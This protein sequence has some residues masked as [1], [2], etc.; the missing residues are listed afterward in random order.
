VSCLDDTTRRRLQDH[1]SDGLMTVIGS[2]HSA[3]LGIPGMAPLSAELQ[4]VMP[5]RAAAA[6]PTATDAW[7]V[8]AAKLAAGA[9]LEAALDELDSE[10]SLITEVVAATAAFLAAAESRVLAEVLDG[11]RP[12]ALTELLRHLVFAGD[13][14][15]VTTNYDRVIE[16]AVELAGFALDCSF[17]GMHACPFDAEG[18]RAA[19]R[20][21]VEIKGKKHFMRFRRHIRLW[22]PHG[23]LDWYLRNGEPF[24]TPYSV[25]LQRLMITPGAAKYLRGYDR[26]FDRH[27]EEA[28]RAIDA[29]GRFLTI[30]YGFNDPHLQTHL[31]PRI[32]AGIP[33]LMLTRSLT[34]A[35]TEL[36]AAASSTVVALVGRPGGGTL[37]HTGGATQEVPDAE[38]WQLDAFID[39]VLK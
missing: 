33:T 22:K 32:R 12:L 13:A 15:V 4:R 24:R 21:H 38:L 3:A 17:L 23:S 9:G 27:R 30:G 11:T 7:E 29:A 20:S 1:F 6:A 8:V 36:V 19:L 31:A 14:Q 25:G 18:S 34:D 5:G 26:P 37:I 39:E 28:N 35:A 10:S 16:L 2:G